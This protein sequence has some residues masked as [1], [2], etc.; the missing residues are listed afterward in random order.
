MH[1]RDETVTVTSDRFDEARMRGVILQRGAKPANR[2]VE[3]KIALN[4]GIRPNGPNDLSP[5][6][7]LF[8]AL[9]EQS[10]YVEWF[11]LKG[12]PDAVVEQFAS[13]KVHHES[14]KA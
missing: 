10:E 8:R 9:G 4:V 2:N 7:Q 14:T 11:V 5:R 6:D 13:I 1:R 3:A 12:N